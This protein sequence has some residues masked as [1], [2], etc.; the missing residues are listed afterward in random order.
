M[1]CGSILTSSA[2]FTHRKRTGVQ[3]AF[4]MGNHCG[5]ADGEH[6]PFVN[7]QRLTPKKKDLISAMAL[8][9]RHAFT[10]VTNVG[11]ARRGIVHE[12]KK[13]PNTWVAS[14]W[15]R[16]SLAGFVKFTIDPD[17]TFLYIL[18]LV[19][20]PAWQKKGIGSTLIS[21]VKEIAHRELSHHGQG[22]G[23]E[24]TGCIRLKTWAT[25]Y[26]V[27]QFYQKRGFV[28]ETRSR[29]KEANQNRELQDDAISF[30]CSL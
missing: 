16:H 10:C 1:F 29:Q 17:R 22:L 2:V 5:K 8:V 18:T 4:A 26:E 15:V 7:V 3:C 24:H 25:N 28:E 12:L 9:E 21:K 27:I 20:H 23:H 11:G 6:D 30:S 19:T 14:A 13:Y